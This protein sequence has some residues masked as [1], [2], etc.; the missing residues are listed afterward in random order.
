MIEK[1][2]A[3]ELAR[4]NLP[5][6]LYTEWYWQIDLH[7]L[8]HFL[9]LRM[10]AHAQKE[11]R[12][13]ATIMAEIARSV[14]PLAMESFDRHQRNSLRFSGEE[15]QVLKALLATHL[16]ENNELENA[17]SA[18]GLDEKTIQRLRDK[19]NKGRQV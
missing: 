4:I 13:Y 1:G 17:G 10:D 5:V 6:S 19:I 8:F 16:N 7:N 15:W 18:A 2:L 14:C 9:R 11:I 3:R 12:D